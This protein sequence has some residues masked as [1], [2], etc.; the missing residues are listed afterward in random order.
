LDFGQKA[1]STRNKKWPK[2]GR[3]IR[4]SK[5]KW[6]TVR[7]KDRSEREKMFKSTENETKRS[8]EKVFSFEGG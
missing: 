3:K 8:Q 1:K 4:G 6:K 5:Q 7:N 2:G